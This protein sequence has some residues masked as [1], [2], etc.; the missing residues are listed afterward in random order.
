MKPI[1]TVLSIAALLCTASV[2]AELYKSVGPDGKVTYSD[3]PP[4][5]A[6]V[7]KKLE[8]GSGKTIDAGLPYELAQAVKHSPVTLYTT[9][10]CS[11]CDDGRKLLGDRGVPFAEKTVRSN[12]DIQRLKQAGG[13]MQLPFLVIGRSTQQGFEAGAWNNGLAA[14]GYP[15]TSTLPKNYRRPPAEP[16][17]PTVAVTP[18]QTR[19]D[20]AAQQPNAPTAAPTAPATATGNAPPGFRF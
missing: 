5:A 17:A 3:T 15:E 16:A 7:E 6:S 10:A 8:T 12:D 9:S 13:D 14:A 19:Q 20:S 11:A 2:H 1:L 4:A 18:P